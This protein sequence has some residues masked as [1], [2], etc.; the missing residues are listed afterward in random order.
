MRITFI[1]LNIAMPTIINIEYFPQKFNSWWTSSQSQLAFM[2]KW[3]WAAAKQLYKCTKYKNTETIKSSRSHSFSLSPSH[4]K[5]LH[6]WGTIILLWPPFQLVWK[7][8]CIFLILKSIFN[9]NMMWQCRNITVIVIKHT[10]W[11]VIASVDSVIMYITALQIRVW[12]Y[13]A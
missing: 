11:T 13:C 6:Y 5:T 4:L 2:C 9:C 7:K 10:S 3:H 8:W 12:Q 1:C